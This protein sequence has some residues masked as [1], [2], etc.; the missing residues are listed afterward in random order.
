MSQKIDLSE[1]DLEYVQLLT[2]EIKFIS[3]CKEMITSLGLSVT[4]THQHDQYA[5]LEL[6]DKGTVIEDKI[7]GTVAHHDAAVSA[8]FWDELVRFAVEYRQAHP[9]EDK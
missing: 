3:K 1:L 5:H 7:T 2:Q 4:L 6:S 8:Y 9:L